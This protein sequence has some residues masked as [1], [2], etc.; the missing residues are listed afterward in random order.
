MP[1]KVQQRSR[2]KNVNTGGG[3][4]IIINGKNEKLGEYGL[5]LFDGISDEK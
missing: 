2:M 1:E 3:K 4:K 5:Y